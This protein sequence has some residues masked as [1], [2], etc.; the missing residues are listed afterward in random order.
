MINLEHVPSHHRPNR[1]NRG[2]K[3]AIPQLLRVLSG[4]YFNSE[5]PFFFDRGNC[6]EDVHCAGINRPYSWARADFQFKPPVVMGNPC[7]KGF[8]Q[9]CDGA[10]KLIYPLHH[11]V[12]K[13]E[14]PKNH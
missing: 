9:L 5:K 7:S 12:R 6:V 10:G 3:P 14:V 11:M 1:H 2:H 4:S 8:V 13:H